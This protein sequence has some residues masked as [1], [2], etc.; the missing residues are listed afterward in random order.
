[1]AV[2]LEKIYINYILDNKTYFEIVK[3]HYFKNNEIQ[4]NCKVFAG[5]DGGSASNAG[6]E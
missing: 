5:D 3:P 6:D 4:I 2:Q 1:M